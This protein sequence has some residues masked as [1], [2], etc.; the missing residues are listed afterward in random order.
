MLSEETSSRPSTFT[1][2]MIDQWSVETAYDTWDVRNVYKHNRIDQDYNKY[3]RW[4]EVRKKIF[5]TDRP[6]VLIASY[7]LGFQQDYKLFNQTFSYFHF[8]AT[9]TKELAAINYLKKLNDQITGNSE[10]TKTLNKYFIHDINLLVTEPEALN[11]VLKRENITNMVIMGQSWE[12][13]IKNRPVG[14]KNLDLTKCNYYV[15][16]EL[17]YKLSGDQ[18]TEQDLIDC[19]ETQWVKCAN[20]TD[21]EFEQIKIDPIMSTR[22]TVAM[23]KLV[24]V[25]R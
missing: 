3:I 18:M 14:L 7:N 11:L 10:K 13:C 17:C 12:A 2:M 24:R 19:K 22:E 5:Y 20:F 16:P 15:I 6:Y 1:F 9:S 23:Y 8:V 21:L 4:L 25:I